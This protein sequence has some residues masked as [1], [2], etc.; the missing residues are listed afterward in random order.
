MKRYKGSLAEFSKIDDIAEGIGNA[1]NTARDLPKRLRARGLE[2]K[3]KFTSLVDKATGKSARDKVAQAKDEAE[4]I[5][6][7]RG[8]AEKIAKDEA[9]KAVRNARNKKIAIGSTI[10]GVG[11]ASGLAYGGVKLANKEKTTKQEEAMQEY[12]SRRS[13]MA[14]FAKE[15]PLFDR[16]QE[17]RKNLSSAIDQQSIAE[18]LG[19]A[20]AGAYAVGKSAASIAGTPERA[21]VNKGLNAAEGSLGRKVA[22][23]AKKLGELG[24]NANR[25]GKRGAVL[26]ALAGRTVTGK[27]AR[28]GAAGLAVKGVL[29]KKKNQDQFE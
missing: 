21:L 25:T 3:K 17:T 8:E 28:L 29:G 1:V 22:E 16:M 5:A 19:S 24:F 26:N 10:G 14:S 4:K 23:G 15:K 6:K 11:L 27:L 7:A 13:K 9:E 20:G 2:S 12:R 18:K